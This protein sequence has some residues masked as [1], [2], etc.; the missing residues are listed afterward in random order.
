MDGRGKMLSVRLRCRTPVLRHSRGQR[1]AA[2]STPARVWVRFPLVALDRERLLG[3]R[4]LDAV[5]C[6]SVS[7]YAGEAGSIP[8]SVT[9]FTSGGYSVC[10]MALQGGA[11]H[12]DRLPHQSQTGVH[13]TAATMLEASGLLLFGG[14]GP[15]VATFPAPIRKY[16]R[17]LR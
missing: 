5:P 9:V 10:L 13:Q 3:I 11:W 14:W 16:A 17:N 6:E 1:C 4:P 2:G 7:R 15:G 12:F 8:A